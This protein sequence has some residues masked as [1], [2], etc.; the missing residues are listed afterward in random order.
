M[1]KFHHYIYAIF[2]LKILFVFENLKF[3]IIHYVLC[4]ELFYWKKL[5]NIAFKFNTVTFNILSDGQS[6]P[7]HYTCRIW[8]L[9]NEQYFKR[10]C[11]GTF[12]RSLTYIKMI[13]PGNMG[14]FEIKLS[15]KSHSSHYN[16][17]KYQGNSSLFL[18]NFYLR[19]NN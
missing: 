2:L 12:G 6:A 15:T 7:T 13:F 5:F 10:C 17:R 16:Y 8:N 4:P 19:Q 14:T 9:N 18:N 11:I 1:I 3:C